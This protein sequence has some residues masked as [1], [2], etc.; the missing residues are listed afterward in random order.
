MEEEER[1]LPYE[2]RKR[3]VGYRCYSGMGLLAAEDLSY[4]VLGNIYAKEFPPGK[5]VWEQSLCSLWFAN[6]KY[7]QYRFGHTVDLLLSCAP[8]EDARRVADIA[9]KTEAVDVLWDLGTCPLE[10]KYYRVYAK[11]DKMVAIRTKAAASLAVA[12]Y[13]VKFIEFVRSVN[14][15][16]PYGDVRTF[17]YATRRRCPRIAPPPLIVP[18]TGSALD[19]ILSDTHAEG[20]SQRVNPTQMHKGVLFPVWY[21]KD[22]TKGRFGLAPLVL[23]KR[24]VHYMTVREFAG[25][26]GTPDKHLRRLANAFDIFSLEECGKKGFYDDIGVYCLFKEA[27]YYLWESLI[28]RTT[29]VT[30]FDVA[31]MTEDDPNG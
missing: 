14:H 2:D 4:C 25:V 5:T 11:T 22:D 26:I 23:K 7:P 15:G 10:K 16:I 17:V 13:L 12:G 9:A 3:V 18:P 24:G 30:P 29:A 6:K 8:L 20:P 1:F 21:K 19:H 31:N 28:K 27:G